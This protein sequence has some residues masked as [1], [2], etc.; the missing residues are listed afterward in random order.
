MLWALF[1]DV[2]YDPNVVYQYAVDV[3]DNVRCASKD[4]YQG[5]EFCQGTG[6]VRVC[7]KHGEKSHDKDCRRDHN[8]TKRIVLATGLVASST[9]VAASLI[10]LALHRQHR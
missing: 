4:G 5:D 2:H 1:D 7:K 9:L 3:I 6:Y 10:A 8:A